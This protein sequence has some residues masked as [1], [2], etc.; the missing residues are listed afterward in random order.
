MTL[1]NGYLNKK[2][3]PVQSIANLFR[4]IILLNKYLLDL[5]RHKL[6]KK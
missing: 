4:S 1:A 2:C 6:N 3:V 5:N